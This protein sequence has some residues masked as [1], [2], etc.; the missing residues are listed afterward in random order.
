[1][2]ALSDAF[3]QDPK[4]A[5]AVNNQVHKGN[6]EE[7]TP[8]KVRRA[9]EKQF[10]LEDKALDEKP[11]KKVVSSLIDDALANPKPTASVKE[12]TKGSESDTEMKQDNEEESEAEEEE[13][14]QPRRRGKTTK[15]SKRSPQSKQIKEE[16]PPAVKTSDTVPD[17]EDDDQEEEKNEK[18][19]DDID[20]KRSASPGS[21][22][23]EEEDE[24]EDE[25]LEEEQKASPKKKAKTAPASKEKK[26][27]SSK[28][29]D[30]IQRLKGFINK[31]GVRKIW[32]KELKDCKTSKQQIDKLKSILESLGV[33]GRP[34]LQK[35][36][37]AKAELELKREIES[38]DTSL[39][40]DDAPRANKRKRR[41]IAIS[42]DDE[43]GDDDNE[44]E[45]KPKRQELDVSFLNQDDDDESD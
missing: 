21:T 30:T 37:E 44:E 24:D 20:T 41:H 34:T 38:L 7:L 13:D 23:E 18:K 2:V 45:E 5:E 16:S 42:D 4:V 3:F 28:S 31:C 22:A 9:L 1:M 14:L 39:I 17:D 29:E 15:K 11:W 25:E 26:T 6:L 32:S 40:I 10:N 35:C 27:T 33:H 43:H 19:E 12:E 8:S 36:K